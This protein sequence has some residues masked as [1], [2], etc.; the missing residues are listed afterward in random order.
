[1]TKLA[2]PAR[3]RPG[4]AASSCAPPGS[5]PGLR[6]CASPAP[7]GVG[8]TTLAKLIARALRRPG[9]IVALGGVWDESA[10]RGLPISFRS[11]QAGRIVLGLREAKVRNPV[12]I[13]NEIDK[14]GG[15]TTNFGDPSAALLEVLDPAQNT[16]FRD[17]YLEATVDLS[18][19]L[20]IATANDLGGVPAPLRDRLEIIE[21]PGYTDDEKVDIVRRALWGEQLEVNGLAAGFWTRASAVTHRGQPEAAAGPAASP[22]SAA[23]GVDVTDA[24]IRA[25]VRGYTCES[26]VRDLARRLGSICQWLACLRV[27]TRDQAPVTVVADADEAAGLEPAPRHVTVAEIDPATLMPMTGDGPQIVIKGRR[28]DWPDGAR[29]LMPRGPGREPNRQTFWFG[30]E[31]HTV[32][33]DRAAAVRTARRGRRH[34][35]LVSLRRLPAAP[36]PSVLRPGSPPG[37][38]AASLR[39]VL[40]EGSRLSAA[41]APRR[42]E[43]LLQM[44]ATALPVIPILDQLRLVSFE[45]FDAP[46]VPRVPLTSRSA[47]IVAVVLLAR[48]TS[49]IGTRPPHLHTI[50][51]I[52][53]PRPA[54]R[55]PVLFKRRGNLLFQDPPAQLRT[56][57]RAG[58]GRM[59]KGLCHVPPGHVPRYARW[60]RRSWV[61]PTASTWRTLYA[62][63]AAAVGCFPLTSHTPGA[64]RAPRMGELRTPFSFRVDQPGGAAPHLRLDDPGVT[65]RPTSDE[66]AA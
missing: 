32:Q 6:S 17:V 25:V 60:V 56:T 12:M 59:A 27:E 8:K 18:E 58:G 21:A 45:A 29:T 34:V 53:S 46:H 64:T 7:P 38:P 63:T 23:G 24:A 31:L 1:M 66:S 5:P 51:W 30:D 42:L 36:L 48:H 3:R 26:G 61:H 19:V 22:S 62:Y 37:T 33:R 47:R 9:V 11:P 35:C 50:S 57:L 14:V 10:I 20:F 16:H 2:A 44:L 28:E 52:F 13:L 41:G 39:P 15:A 49:R 54:N 65:L 55:R 40:G 43:L 4:C